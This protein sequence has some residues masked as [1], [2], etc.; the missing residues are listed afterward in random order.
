MKYGS[1][2]EYKIGC[3]DEDSVFDY[4]MENLKDT[5]KGWDF[6][7]GWEKVFGKVVG[8]EAELNIL[9]TLIGKEN[10]REEFIKIVTNHPQTVEILPVLIA[11][12]EKSLKVLQPNPNNIFNFLEYSFKKNT[13]MSLEEINHIADFA[14]NS[15]ILDLL[16]NTKIKNLVDYVMGVEVGLDSNARKNRSGNAMESITELLIKNICDKCSFRYIP[17]ATAN[18]IEK[19]F[20]YK[21]LADKSERAFD[22][23]VDTGRKLYLIET[24][25]YGGGGSKLKAVAG[26]FTTLCNF[27]KKH[28]PE[29]GF[30]WVTDGKGWETTRKPLKESFDKIDYILNLKMLEKGVLEEILTKGE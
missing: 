11:I 26:E 8:W 27:L 22:Y 29:H 23:A 4:F 21:V 17:Q 24:N 13:R 15:G 1:I 7:V 28:T 9:N 18:K 10:I 20:G 14:Q 30:I 6:F 3:T 12:R 25:Y 5:I 2:F 16:K 19:N